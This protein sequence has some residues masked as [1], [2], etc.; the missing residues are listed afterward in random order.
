MPPGMKGRVMFFLLRT[1]F[2]ISVVLVLLPTG[3]TKPQ[4]DA[5]K[6]GAVDAI[7]AAS[8]AVSDMSQFCSRNPDACVTGSHAAVAFGQRAQAG[9]KMVYDFLSE[10]LETGSVAPERKNVHSKADKSA[11][12]SQSGKTVKVDRPEKQAPAKSQHTLKP[13]DLAPAY[14]DPPRR[15]ATNPQ[16]R[17]KRG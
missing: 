6:V 1:A 4:S 7:S 10:R 9:A 12:K 2:W 15:E 17:D 3:E 8:S 14:R 16:P 13:S 11:D 5:A